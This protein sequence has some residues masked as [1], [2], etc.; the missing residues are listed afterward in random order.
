MAR[1]I[2]RS[3]VLADPGEGV[4]LN[5]LYKRDR[6]ICHLCGLRVAR[7][8]ATRDHLRPLSEGGPNTYD[9]TKLA[10]K[11]CNQLRG[12]LSVMAARELLWVAKSTMPKHL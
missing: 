12:D 9:N 11:T 6:G 2:Q 3:R 5:T 10:H 7:R 8:N 4:D 1:R